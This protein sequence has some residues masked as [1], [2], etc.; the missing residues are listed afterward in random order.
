VVESGSHMTWR[1]V[2][3]ALKARCRD[4]PCSQPPLTEFIA[5]HRATTP[6]HQVVY[7]RPEYTMDSR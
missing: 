2:T 7:V 6:P 4:D 3:R 5:W 1:K